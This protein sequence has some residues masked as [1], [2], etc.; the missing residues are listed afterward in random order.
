MPG[1]YCHLALAE[2]VYRQLKIS[3]YRVD[4]SIKGLF[5]PNMEL[6]EKDLLV[7]EDS[8]K[9][10]MFCHLYFDYNFVENFLIPEFEWSYERRKI[11]NPN[12]KMEWDP[13]PFFM[14]GGIYYTGFNETNYLLVEEGYVS[15]Q[16]VSEL[17]EVLP[18]TGIEIFDARYETTWK[19]EFEDY[20]KKKVEYTGNIFNYERL[21]NCIHKTSIQLTQKIIN[22]KKG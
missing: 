5:I 17:P 8:I 11:I 3:H 16:N 18:K 19:S 15:M 14:K 12:N 4:A 22:S 9:L 10:G 2:K 21:K 7:L 13:E 6:V 20:L 1:S